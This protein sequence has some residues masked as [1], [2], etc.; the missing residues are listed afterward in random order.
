MAGSRCRPNRE[1]K[2][3]M[4]GGAAACAAHL[5]HP[6]H[7]GVDMLFLMPST[8]RFEYFWLADWIAK[9]GIWREFL[10]AARR[11]Q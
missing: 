4:V 9:G 5:R 7:T 8:A 11:R 3:A 1:A 6:E 2:R 10:D